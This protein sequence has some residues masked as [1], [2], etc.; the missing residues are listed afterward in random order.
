L[1]DGLVTVED[2]RHADIARGRDKVG[3]V[4]IYNKPAASEEQGEC[5]HQEGEQIKDAG[6]PHLERGDASANQ[7]II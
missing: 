7:S 5:S 3:D 6:D 2:E 4:A 1:P